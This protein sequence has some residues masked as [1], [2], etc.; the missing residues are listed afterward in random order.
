MR[1]TA[2]LPRLRSARRIGAASLALPLAL[3]MTVPAVVTPTADA[4]SSISEG[5]GAGSGTDSIRPDSYPE[6]TPIETEHRDIQ[7]LP[8]GVEETRVEW[9]TNRWAN[10]Y[11]KSA[12]MPEQEMKVQILLARDW[13]SKPNQTFPSVWALDGLRARDDESGWT[14]ETNIHDFYADKN[15]NVIM[16]VGGESSFY[17]DW[18]QPNNGKNYKWETFLT[19]ELPAVLKQGWRTNDDRAVVGLS[20]GGTAAINLAERHPHMFKFAGSFSGYLDTTSYGMPQAIGYATNDGGGYDAQKMWGP[21]GSQDWVD[22]DPKLGVEN[23]KG[24]GVYV[25]AGNGNTG[26]FDQNGAIPGIPTNMA[27]FGLEVMSRL[28]TETFVRYAKRAGVDV[29]TQFRPSGTH[30]WPYWQ[31]EMTQAWPHIANSLG[32][33]EGDRGATCN[34]GGDIKKK[35]DATD[36]S[37]QVGPCTSEEYD[38]KNGGKVQDYRN[39]RA[40]WKPGIGANFLWGRIGALY[41][42]MGAEGSWLGYPTSQ[43]IAIGPG[44]QG[45]IVHFEHGNI[46]WH[47][48]TGAVAIHNNMMDKYKEMGYEHGA[49]GYPTEQL[50][51]VAGGQVLKFQNGALLKKPN[52][53]VVSVQGLISNK[54]FEL[55]GPESELGW[56]KDREISIPGGAFSQFEHGNIYWSP[57]SGAHMI[58]YGKIFDKW[59]EH[60]YEQGKYGWPTEDFRAIPSGG[61]EQVFQKGTI[62]EINGGVQEDFRG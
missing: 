2:K 44:N 54:Y 31:F 11:I 34:I 25:S 23:L 22:H 20:M 14:L 29:I 59:G 10:I 40:Y 8:Q 7:G 56:P 61:N 17:T 9:I 19:Q 16:P 41:A 53:E 30:S 21:Y 15:V 12:A 55:G 60:G 1:S 24:M 48:S 32:L 37:G 47:P 13:Y 33:A 43:E 58:K 3:G 51:D 4:Q 45:R 39:G 42:G 27:G 62:R 50:K 57:N 49:L 35:Y 52:G 18:Q 5:W 26:R 38:G 46:Y 28:T 6:R 36:M